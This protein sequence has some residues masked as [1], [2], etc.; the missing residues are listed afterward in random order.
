[1][2]DEIVSGNGVDAPFSALFLISL[3]FVVAL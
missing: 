1:M 2:F 3:E